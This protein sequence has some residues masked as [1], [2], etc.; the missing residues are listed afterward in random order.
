MIAAGRGPDVEGLGL[1]EADVELDEH[2]LVAVDGALRTS[3]AGVYA[4]G[5]LVPGPALAHKA[6]DEGIIAAEDD[7]RAARPIRST[8]IDIPRATFCTPNVGVFGL[9][10]QQ[11]ATPATTSSSA[12]CQYGAVGAGTVYGDRTGLVKIVGDKRYGELLGGH[13][14]GVRATEL[15]QELVNVRDAR[16]RLRG[17]RAHRPRPPD[18]VGGRHG[19]RPR[20][21]RL[22]HPRVRARLTATRRRPA[23]YFDLGSPEAYLSAERVLQVDAGRRRV[24]AGARRGAA[25]RRRLRGLP[26]RRGARGRAGRSSARPPR[27]ACSPCAGRT[28]SRSTARY[29]MRVATYARQIGRT[30][31]FALAAFRQ[32]YAGGRALEVPD[33]RPDRRERVRDAPVGGAQGRRHAARRERAGPRDPRGGRSAASRRTPAVWL[34]TGDVLHGDDRLE[35]AA[36]ALAARA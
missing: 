23:F 29:A 20:R 15:I 33:E 4:I 3:N 22:A 27:A 16:G 8:T 21:G 36:A 35:A 7:R 31:A 14:V 19:G 5:D 9:T 6:S 30:V 2:G 32:A 10:E 25:G 11:A 24:D 28:R 12:R 1:D 13:I 18:A 17:G 26:L 34:P